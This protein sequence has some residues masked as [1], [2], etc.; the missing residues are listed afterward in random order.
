MSGSLG[1]Y[2][3]GSRRA[4]NGQLYVVC[5]CNNIGLFLANC[6]DE[7]FV[8]A[9]CFG[10]VGLVRMCRSP[11]ARQALESVLETYAGLWSFITRRHS[12]SRAVEEGDST[13]EKTDHRFL[14]LVRQQ[15]VIVQARGVINDDV[16]LVVAHAVATN[17][18]SVSGDAVGHLPEPGHDLAVDVDQDMRPVSLAPLHLRFGIQLAQAPETQTA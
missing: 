5:Q 16:V 8:F 11:R 3:L 15:L 1:I 10:R 17:P 13:A 14:L 9:V 12:I 6:L 4:T 2:R 7:S 18:L